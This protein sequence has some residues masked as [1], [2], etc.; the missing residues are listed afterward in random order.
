M[1]TLRFRDTALRD[2]LVDQKVCKYDELRKT[3]KV[4]RANRERSRQLNQEMSECTLSAA[5]A[6]VQAVSPRPAAAEAVGVE[7]TPGPRDD[8]D[9]RAFS[10]ERDAYRG[11][12]RSQEGSRGGGPSSARYRGR[13]S[14]PPERRRGPGDARR[15]SNSP[16]WGGRSPR[17][18]GWDSRDRRRN[19]PYP[20]RA[21]RRSGDSLSAGSE[22]D[23]PYCY[24]CFEDGHTSRYCRKTRCYNCQQRGHQA[25]D[26]MNE[27]YCQRCGGE[28]HM[29]TE[30]PRRS[31]EGDRSVSF[32]KRGGRAR[33]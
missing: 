17:Q 33:S 16:R 21:R 9:S 5:P 11:R 25:R 31:R 29:E 20:G 28:G 7:T 30:C 24:K 22:G 12:D 23:G 2:K 3:L 8:G 27:P 19:S 18:Q 13:D 14:S 4:R 15:R 10:R 26:C 32:R 6:R 1:T